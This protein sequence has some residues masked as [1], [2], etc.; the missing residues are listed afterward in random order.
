M[1][2]EQHSQFSHAIKLSLTTVEKSLI[3]MG[4]TNVNLHIFSGFNK[5]NTCFLKM[6]FL[7]TGKS[8]SFLSHST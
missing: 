4:Y 5:R 7:Q 8:K 1:C 3:L 2:L 6:M